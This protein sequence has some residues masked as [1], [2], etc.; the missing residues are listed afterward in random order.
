MKYNDEAWYQFHENDVTDK[1]FLCK[2]KSEDL[3]VVRH[4]KSMKMVH[5][6]CYCMAE[7]PADYLLDNTRPWP[8]RKKD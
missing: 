2:E 1:C 5:L 6:C 8:G 3:L 7:Y 4:I